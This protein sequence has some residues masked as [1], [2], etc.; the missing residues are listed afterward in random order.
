[1]TTLKKLKVLAKANKEEIH[2]FSFGR[3]SLSSKEK[4]EYDKKH[5]PIVQA[6]FGRGSLPPSKRN[7]NE[8]K[9]VN[10]DLKEHF[11]NYTPKDKSAIREYTRD[12][13]DLNNRLH[14]AAK[15]KEEVS[16]FDDEV[17]A[18][19][20]AIRRHH[21]PKKM[22]VYS[23]MSHSPEGKDVIR[24]PAY[25]STST[26]FDQA[27]GFAYHDKKSKLSHPDAEGK[28]PG[29]VIKLDVPEGHPAGYF[30]DHSMHRHEEEVGLGRNTV[31]YKNGEP[32]YH[33]HNNVWVHPFTLT[34]T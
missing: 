23:G 30:A 27:T 2:M 7:I 5:A 32:K 14:G 21:T 24:H 34:P 10:K 1:M 6:C 9:I 25:L 17:S 13:F 15:R 22:T 19:D 11:T 16:P 33:K 12:S 29:H 20:S 8:D 31:M 26:D 28:T 4:I 18:L 3:H